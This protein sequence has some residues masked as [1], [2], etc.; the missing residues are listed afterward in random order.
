MMS[1]VC[2]HLVY[3]NI[4]ELYLSEGLEV[5]PTYLN[6]LHILNTKVEEQ[7]ILLDNIFSRTDEACMQKDPMLMYEPFF[8]F[9]NLNESSV[10][11][12]KI[13][14]KRKNLEYKYSLGSLINSMCE[15]GNKLSIKER[16]PYIATKLKFEKATKVKSIEYTNRYIFKKSNGDKEEIKE[17]LNTL[18]ES[19]TLQ[20]KDHFL[21]MKD[22]TGGYANESNAELFTN[23]YAEY[24]LFINRKKTTQAM[25][26]SSLAH[27]ESD[28]GNL[29]NRLFQLCYV[30][31]DSKFIS[32]DLDLLRLIKKSNNHRKYLYLFTTSKLKSYL[33]NNLLLQKL[34]LI[35]SI[36]TKNKSFFN[37][38]GL[39]V[40]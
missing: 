24:I 29:L 18:L 39:T 22:E 6:I 35:V 37:P 21:K 40:I 38:I 26:Y 36:S 17:N 3:R 2:D 16:L 20:Y 13:L 31:K 8:G 27:K 28:Y 4:D 10:E 12:S 15:M 33:L 34:G 1:L 9:L 32:T 5:K 19:L 30:G 14:L 23:V 7:D 11:H 25:E